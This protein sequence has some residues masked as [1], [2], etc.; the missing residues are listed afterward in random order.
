MY[1]AAQPIPDNPSERINNVEFQYERQFH[2]N[3]ANGVMATSYALMCYL[4]RNDL[5]TAVPIM[6][7]IASQRNRVMGWSSTQVLRMCIMLTRV[8]ALTV[9]C[10]IVEAS[11]MRIAVLN[12]R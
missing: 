2:P 8:S 3:V 6:K 9:G 10:R 11:V 4:A 7:F 12:F 5:K 1:W